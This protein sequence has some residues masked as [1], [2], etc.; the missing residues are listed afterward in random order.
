MTMV[1]RLM[2]ELTRSKTLNTVFNKKYR[3]LR[4]LY[5][6]IF[7]HLEPT[8]PLI[9]SLLFL[10]LYSRLYSIQYTVMTNWAIPSTLNSTNI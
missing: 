3:K 1:S 9:L 5:A 8:V 2:F 6:A 10:I 7:G 4:F